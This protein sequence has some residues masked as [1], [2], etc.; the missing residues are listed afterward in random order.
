MRL[1]ILGAGGIGCYYAAR[2]IQAGHEVVLV[3]RGEHLR[4]LQS[5]GLTLRHPSLQ[6][7]HQ[8]VVATD[9]AGLAKGWQCADFD[10]LVLA[11]KGMATAGMMAT[12]ADW[13]A[14][15][16][17]PVLSIQNGV[18]NEP[19]IAAVV[20]QQRTLGGLAVRIGGHIIS[21]GV[22]EATGV[23]QIEMGVWPSQRLNPDLQPWA[24]ALAST[25]IDAGIPCRYETDIQQALWRKLVINNGVNPLS[26]LT[27]LTTRPMTS[28]P[29][30][31]P[32][33]QEL[34]AETVRAAQANDVALADSDADA[35]YQLICDFDDIKTSMLV[36]FE[37]NRALELAEICGP[38]IDGCRATGLPATTTERVQRLL[39]LRLIQKSGD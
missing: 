29:V 9:L 24:E 22:V 17:T 37:K 13:L 26:A 35:M 23:A 39:Q 18:T 25:F 2:L 11:A 8:P 10:L 38:V 3:A 31:G 27:G 32:M 28:D 20:G 6:L 7:Q 33:V 12:L 21:P 15:A 36:D 34:M 30:L 14:T 4:A 1:L 5:D 16:Q 19:E